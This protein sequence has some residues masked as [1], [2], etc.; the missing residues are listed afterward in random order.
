[1]PW[2]HDWTRAEERSIPQG[3]DFVDVVRFPL[4]GGVSADWSGWAVRGQIR[5]GYADDAPLVADLDCVIVDP[6]QRVVRFRL[7][8]A[9]SEGI[10]DQ[11]GRWDAELVRGEQV[12]RFV[13]GKWELDREVT[14]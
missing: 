9:V 12:V 10:K 2:T 14:R 5:A 7:G 1:M 3:A 6:V 11:C 8:A 13:V 4:T